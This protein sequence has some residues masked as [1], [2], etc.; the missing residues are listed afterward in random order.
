[1]SDTVTQQ[2]NLTTEQTPELVV[3]DLTEDNSVL[4]ARKSPLSPSFK[5]LYILLG[6]LIA[7]LCVIFS[8][9]WAYSKCMTPV[10]SEVGVKPDYSN[11]EN[12]LIL[13]AF[14]KIDCDLNDIDNSKAG[15]IKV[16]FRFFGLFRIYS[17]L[18]FKDTTPPAAPKFEITIS[19]KFSPTPDMFLPMVFDYSNVSLEIIKTNYVLNTVGTYDISFKA[20]DIHGN[21]TYFDCILNSVDTSEILN[22]GYGKTLDD[23]KSKIRELYPDLKNFTSIQ[24]LTKGEFQAIGHSD[25][26][27]YILE[28]ALGDLIPPV[29]TGVKDLVHIIG[30]EQPQYLHGVSAFDEVWGNITVSVDT[31]AVDFLTPNIYTIT[32]TATDNSGNTSM[33][34]AHIT[35][36]K[37]TRVQLKVSNILQNPALPNGCEVVSL[38]IALKYYGYS[39]NPLE[40][41]E[42]YMPK[43]P[44]WQGDPW[45]NYIG[46]ATGVGYGCYAPCV[47]KTGNDY[48]SSIGSDKKVY[49]VSG[50]S[51]K[52]YED[53]IDNSTPVVF[54][55]LIN[56][57]CDKKIAWKT[58]I[59]G[60]N[61]VWHSFSHCLVLIGYTDHTYIFC[62]PR[63]SKIVEYDKEKVE[64]SFEI[65]Y[66][67]ACIIK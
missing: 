3:V 55:G 49:D 13:S 41:Y 12:N 54:W 24:E 29:I 16:P 4:T 53:Y 45:E 17:P 19:E 60:K 46:D 28:V 32:Y 62:D 6:V 58:K 40:L 44:M 56:M 59:N 61:I 66:R 52:E 5:A 9:A 14:T 37:P 15:H 11:F 34:K 22:F 50:L 31:S 30:E 38:A 63:K 21:T 26:H 1:M 48:L 10:T 7:I 18:E 43:V 33:Q 65:N 2:Q 35:V 39:I 51:M 25:D 57:N 20:A 64:T 23:V 27:V 36:K 47:V 42:T 67:Q 8:S